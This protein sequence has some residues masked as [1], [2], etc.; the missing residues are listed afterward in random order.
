MVTAL[1][2]ALAGCGTEAPAPS[3]DAE[4][5][6]TRA[7]VDLRGRLPSIAEL[8][9]A[10]SDPSSVDGMIEGFLQDGAFGDRVADLFAPT[11]RTRVDRLTYLDLPLDVQASLGEEPLRVLARV[12]GEDLPYTDLVTGDWTMAD[13]RVA[14]VWPVEYPAG[15]TGWRVSRYTD[16]RP[17]AGVLSGNGL[18]WRYDTTYENY[19]RGRANALSRILLCADF[20]ERPVHF[21][22]SADIFDAG[23]LQTEVMSNP[24]CTSCHATLDP[25]ASYLYGFWYFADLGE[26]AVYTPASERSWMALTGMAPSFFG[27]PGWRLED[28][29]AQVAGD[30]RFIQCAVETAWEALLRRPAAAEDTDRLTAHREAFLDGGVRLRS[31]VRSIVADPAYRAAGAAGDPDN[32]RLMTP[33]SLALVVEDLTGFRWTFDGRPLLGND[34]EGLRILAGGADG[35]EVTAEATRPNATTLLVQARLAEAASLW[36]V[37]HDAERPAEDRLFDGLDLAWRPDA[38]RAAMAEV[39]TRL[40][41][42]VLGHAAARDADEVELAL[43]LWSEALDLEG[44]PERAWAAVLTWMLRDPELVIY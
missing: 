6:L 7:S 11:Y 31:L 18:W 33:E 2:L 25:M 34:V 35:Y 43:G 12:A 17:A 1:W 3:V 37:A 40:Y 30:P 26:Q 28:L 4:A 22:R 38:D 13:E 24:S 41:R 14:S 9:R 23:T 5:L 36:A 42:R 44:A 32:A 8:D 39:V 29:G 21:E 20:L 16:G 19:N 10:A 15:A 27:A